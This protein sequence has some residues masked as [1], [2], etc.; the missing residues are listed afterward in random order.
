M[1]LEARVLV[2]V[3]GVVVSLWLCVWLTRVVLREMAKGWEIDAR[4]R[5]AGW[6][7][8][9]ERVG[10]GRGRGRVGVSGDSSRADVGTGD[11][12]IGYSDSR[13]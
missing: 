4:R 6:E 13:H 8:G 9:S 12:T 7:R 10:F 3:V 11:G 5:G 2:L 1:S